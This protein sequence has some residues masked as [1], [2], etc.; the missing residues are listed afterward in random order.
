MQLAAVRQSRTVLAVAL[1]V[2][3]GSSLLRA[4][5]IGGPS[6]ESSFTLAL[7]YVSP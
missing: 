3:V 4:A 5:L 6:A 2:L 7:T 1:C